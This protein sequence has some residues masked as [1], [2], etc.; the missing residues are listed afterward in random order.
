[1]LRATNEPN[2][3]SAPGE[4]AAYARV[5]AL[6]ER[7]D[8]LS[9]AR[10]ASIVVAERDPVVREE[11]L[12]AVE[13]LA[14][15]GG[16]GGL[17]DEARETVR[18]RLLERATQVW[19]TGLVVGD[20][21]LSSGRVEDRVGVVAAIEDAVAVAVVEDVMDPDEAEALAGPGRRILE[22]R[23]LAGSPSRAAPAPLWEPS[24]EDW[25]AA[26]REAEGR[27]SR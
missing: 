23:P 9:P 2:R 16:R 27:R 5:E 12:A 25:A 15:G 7:I 8:L 20:M 6:F 19:P 17:L 22:L 26:D 14:D 4:R 3:L 21:Q 10:L 13:R 18:S 24:A 1:M 11:L